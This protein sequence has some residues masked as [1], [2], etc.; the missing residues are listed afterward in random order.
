MSED[1]DRVGLQEDAEESAGGDGMRAQLE[2]AQREKDELQNRLLRT[3]ADYQNLG[4]RAEQN[5]QSARE[6]Q[7]MDIARAVV[8]VLDNF[9]RALEVDPEK[10]SGKDLLVGVQLVREELLRV[11]GR[12]GIERID[13]KSGEA[14]DPNRHEALMR[15]K[16]EG[17]ETGNVVAQL[18]PGYVLKDKTVRAAKVSVAE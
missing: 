11:L 16:A 10:V 12:F 5:V 3:M 2:A 14:F 17:D 7:A 8:G 13:V 6:M 1:N 9:D 15:Q 4:R 18:Q